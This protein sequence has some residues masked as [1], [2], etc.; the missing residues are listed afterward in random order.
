MMGQTYSPCHERYGSSQRSCTFKRHETGSMHTKRFYM[1]GG[2]LGTLSKHKLWMHMTGHW[3][4]VRVWCSSSRFLSRCLHFSRFGRSRPLMISWSAFSTCRCLSPCF[5]YNSEGMISTYPKTK[6]VNQWYQIQHLSFAETTFEFAPH[7][8]KKS[9]AS[10][11]IKSVSL[12]LTRVLV[13]GSRNLCLSLYACH[14]S[15]KSSGQSVLESEPFF[16]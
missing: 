7:I 8:C 14:A 3:L 5:D 1:Y 15:I 16:E 13:G 9:C 10:F 11:F 12:L 6:L 2:N 4:H